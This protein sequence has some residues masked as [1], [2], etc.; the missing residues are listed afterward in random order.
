MSGAPDDLD[1]VELARLMAVPLAEMGLPAPD[2]STDGV[3][4]IGCIEYGDKTPWVRAG[5]LALMEMGRP[6][7]MIRC[8]DHGNGH[9]CDLIAPTDV[10]RGRLSCRGDA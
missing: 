8:A 1:L 2:G 3:S 6:E 4:L 9:D 7:V 10:L 5:A